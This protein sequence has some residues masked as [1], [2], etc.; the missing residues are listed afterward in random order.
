PF[1]PAAGS[2][3]TFSLDDL[4]QGDVEDI[5]SEK[6][7]LLSGQANLKRGSVLGAKATAATV[8][9]PVADAGNTGNGT[10][11]LAGTPFTATAKPGNYRIVA[12]SATQWEVF[13]PTGVFLG[14]ANNTV[15]FSNG[16]VFT[17]TAGG[18]AF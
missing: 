13:D 10:N 11:V 5:L 12:L 17:I 6:V 2:Q 18:T 3:S 8:A 15:Q 4:L 7:T 14:H 9:A 16:I 1:L